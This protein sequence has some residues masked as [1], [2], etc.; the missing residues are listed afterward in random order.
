MKMVSITIACENGDEDL[1]AGELMNSQ[2]AQN[3]LF[4]W[5]TYI[6]EA[7][8]KEIKEVSKQIDWDVI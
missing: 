5:G 2:A 6:R 8:E 7:T 4:C 3:G 1:V